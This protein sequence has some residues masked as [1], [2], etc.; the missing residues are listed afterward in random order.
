MNLKQF[1]ELI[2]KPTI[3]KY[4]ADGKLDYAIQLEDCQDIINNDPEILKA[5]HTRLDEL[6]T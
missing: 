6:K 5:V 2:L 3:L 1:N 4:I